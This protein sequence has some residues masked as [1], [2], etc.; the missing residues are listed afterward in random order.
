MTPEYPA[1]YIAYLVEFHATRDYFECHELLEE[2]WKEHPH[3]GLG[4]LWVGLIQVAVGSYHERRGNRRGALMMYK[5]ALSRLTH[6]LLEKAGLQ[7]ETI[8]AELAA[9]AD[10]LSAGESGTFADMNLAIADERLLRLCL[11]L[12]EERGVVWG[13]PSDM[14]DEQLVHRHTLRDRS[15]VIAARAQAAA[16]RKRP[17]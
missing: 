8:T 4:A 17:E 6:A 11:K 2:Y 3:D 9:R 5:Q 15:G 10:R 16:Q 14:G 13:Q 1:S 7:G 12:C